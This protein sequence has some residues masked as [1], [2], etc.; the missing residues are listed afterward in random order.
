MDEEATR[1]HTFEAVRAVVATVRTTLGPRGKDKMIEQPD[2]TVLITNDAGTILSETVVANPTAK[3]VVDVA[4]AV[5]SERGDGT[6]TAVVLA[7]ALLR[8]A[9]SLVEQGVHP[10]SIVRGY[11]Q[12]LSMARTELDAMAESVEVDTETRRHVVET[13]V[14]GKGLAGDRST[15]VDLV[16]SAAELVS[17]GND[18]E[19]D[20]IRI[21]TQTGRPTD[22]SEVVEGAVLAADP[23]RDSMPK[24]LESGRVVLTEAP[25]QLTDT[26]YD[27]SIEIEDT[28]SFERF[29]QQ[30]DEQVREMVSSLTDVGANAVL[31]SGSIADEAQSALSVEGVLGV[32]QIDDEA[33]R[34]AADVLGGTVVSNLGALTEDHLG[35]G[36]LLRDEDDELYVIRGDH[37]EKRAT[38]LL[39]APTQQVADELERHAE[40]ALDV[41]AGADDGRLVAGGGATEV[42]L[43]GRVRRRADGVPNREQLAVDAFADALE[44]IPRVLAENAGA[45]PLDALVGLRNRHADGQRWAGID[46]SGEIC[47]TFETNVLESATMKTQI[48]NSAAEA[49]NL[50]LR[51]DGML[52]VGDL[53]GDD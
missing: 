13:T 44:S 43:A 21:V 46:E 10:S 37:G 27:T 8:E 42:E 15:L 45:D 25:V 50:V 12:A 24:E 28:E 18:V 1:E 3:L 49:A 51:I 30:E 34:F 29:L 26:G 6:T 39:R 20:R 38:V 7:G 22:D 16:V 31:C 35:V 17:E 36:S 47:D 4:N 5:G 52:T 11:E 19:T 32:R 23:V 14:A 9:E 2:G 48:L 33:L 41:V 40:A 53:S